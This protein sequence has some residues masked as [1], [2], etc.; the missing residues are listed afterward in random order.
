VERK[1]P[2]QRKY[3]FVGRS[4]PRCRET[5]YY[6]EQFCSGSW[7][8]IFELTGWRPS[9]AVVVHRSKLDAEAIRWLAEF[10]KLNGGR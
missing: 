4:D 2:S 5:R 1:R 8:E 7:H 3:E 6:V 10:H 9:R